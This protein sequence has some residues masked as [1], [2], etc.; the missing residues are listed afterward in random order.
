MDDRSHQLPSNLVKPEFGEVNYRREADGVAVSLTMNPTMEGAKADGWQTGV[1]LDASHS[2]RQVYGRGT[3]GTIPPDVLEGYSKLGWVRDQVVD[4]RK[5]R[6]LKQEAHDDAVRRG[7]IR[8]SENAIEPL[9]RDFIAMLADRLD[10]DGG[11]T[12]IYW[13]CGQGDA[14][15]VLGD[16]TATQ[17]RTLKLTGPAHFG[18]GTKLLPAVR[19][20]VDRFADAKKGMYVFLADGNLEDLEAV[21]AYTTQLARA[22][23][24]GRRNF[25]KCVLVG[26]G[27]QVEEGPMEELDDLDTGTSVDIWDHKIALEMRSLMDIFAELADENMIIAPW[28]KIHTTAGKLVKKFITGL[29]AK[30]EF[31]LPPDSTGFVLELPGRR[32]EQPLAGR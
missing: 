5:T 18:N 7:L 32:I 6:K 19:Y 16:F 24:A 2:M 28:A 29:P 31:R 12:V 8:N 26:L 9:A 17:C 27:E 14:I 13:A 4:G 23:E 20:F 30:V 15:E 25:V 1:A 3:I 22:I 11:T 10:E 21:K